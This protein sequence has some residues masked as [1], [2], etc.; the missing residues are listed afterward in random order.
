MQQKTEKCASL[1]TLTLCLCST[2][3]RRIP[4][5]KEAYISG[6]PWQWRSNPQDPIFPLMLNVW[7]SKHF[8]D[9][10]RSALTGTIFEKGNRNLQQ[11]LALRR[12]EVLLRSSRPQED[13]E[14]IL[15]ESLRGFRAVSGTIDVTFYDRQ[16]REKAR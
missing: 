13:A 11:L 7:D 6:A 9:A 10:F 8:Q 3:F 5:G 4:I 2:H 15:L 1:S 12:W 14:K 16:L